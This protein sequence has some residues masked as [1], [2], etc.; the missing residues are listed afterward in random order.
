MIFSAKLSKSFD[1]L[2]ENSIRPLA[3]GRKNYLLSKAFDNRNYP[4]YPI[5]QSGY[6]TLP[7]IQQVI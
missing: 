6:K 7:I 3:L 2:G 1:N 4:K 5:I